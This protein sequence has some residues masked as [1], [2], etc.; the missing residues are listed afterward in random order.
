MFAGISHLAC[1]KSLSARDLRRVD[2]IYWLVVVTKNFIAKIHTSNAH[3][4]IIDFAKTAENNRN[5]RNL[6]VYSLRKLLL[7][8]KEKIENTSR[9]PHTISSK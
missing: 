8:Y 5:I 3:T 4:I 1:G 7:F 2:T 6:F 9:K